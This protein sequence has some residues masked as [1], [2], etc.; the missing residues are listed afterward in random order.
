MTFLQV[1][2][3]IA[4]DDILT[5][6]VPLSS[7]E[8]NVAEDVPPIFVGHRS[9]NHYVVIIPTS[10]LEEAR[11]HLDSI[12]TKVVPYAQKAF[13]ASHV[14][15]PYVYADSF[16]QRHQ[17][18]DFLRSVQGEFSRARLIYFP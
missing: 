2:P 9:P 13:V 7:V 8:A 11:S 15:G 16:E 3:A 10:S 14:L 5:Q 1:E 17:A 6:V 18:S 4:V 12:R